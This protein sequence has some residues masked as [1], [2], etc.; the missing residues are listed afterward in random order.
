MIPAAS[1]AAAG[2]NGIVFDRSDRSTLAWSEKMLLAC[3]ALAMFLVVSRYLWPPLDDNPY[4]KH[5]PL[6]LSLS[7]FALTALG[8]WLSPRRPASGASVIAAA[9]P[10]ALLALFIVGGAA[11]ARVVNGVQASFLNMGLYMG[12]V[13]VGAEVVTHTAA[14]ERLARIYCRILLCG[15][16][17]M[18]LGL[19]VFFHRREVYHEEIFL[20]IP[21]AAYGFLAWRRALARWG[22][23]I[24]FLALA[25]LSGKNTSYLVALLTVAY[26]A[27]LNWS[28]SMDALSPLRRAWRRYLALVVTAAIALIVAY[29]VQHRTTYLPSGNVDYRSYTYDIAWRRFLGSPVWG[30]YFTGRGARKFTLYTVGETHNVLPTHSDVMDLLANGGVLGVGLW[31]IGLVSIARRAWRRLLAPRLLSHPWAPAAHTLALVSAAAAV[32]YAFN[33]VMLQPG[34]SYLM[35]M[36]LGVLLGLALRVGADDNGARR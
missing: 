16:L 17:I 21:L 23:L 4:I 34:M 2:R 8:W 35:W 27:A 12:L 7:F 5:L 13:L 28:H 25:P 22:M 31:A 29:V 6:A 15:A 19:I 9:W 36:S 24:F 3:A 11:Y 1:I 20:V 26:L 10:F 32:T 33:P 14:P 30:T 18:A